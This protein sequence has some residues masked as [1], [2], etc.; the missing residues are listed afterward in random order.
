MG[1]SLVAKAQIK[2][3]KTYDMNTIIIYLPFSFYFFYG[4]E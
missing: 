2:E 3:P 1:K 4:G